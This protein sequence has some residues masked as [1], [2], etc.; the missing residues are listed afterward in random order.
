M[1]SN[2][3]RADKAA[4]RD[5]ARRKA[6][7][8]RALQEKKAKRSRIIAVSGLVAALAILAVVVVM[9][10]N[11]G[12]TST[13]AASLDPKTP[14]AGVTAPAGALDNGGIPVGVDG[15]AG[16]TSG[17]GAVAVAVYYDYMCPVCGDFEKV[18]AAPLD[19]LMR[20][21]DI[22][23]EYH[24]ISILDRLS[25]GTEFSTRSAQAAAYVADADPAH[26]LAFHEAMFANQPAENS[27]GLSDEEI[28]ALAVKAGV[29]QDDADK[30]AAKGG[31]FTTWVAAVT[32]QGT[33]DGVTGTPTVM[34]NGTKTAAD[35]DLLTA[36][37]LEEAIRAA[38]G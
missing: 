18:N 20:A 34:I 23:V 16:T 9:I 28:A 24:P 36:G 10:L 27:A 33:L 35:V 8:L 26:F 3:P 14:L 2:T 30:I 22:T 37:P 4:Q 12:K 5:A 19:A 29:S 11:Q 25:Q 32:A 7:E 15:T 38:K 17:A 13:P 1:P 6:L 31:K 21:G